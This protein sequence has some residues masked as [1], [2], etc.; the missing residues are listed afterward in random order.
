MTKMINAKS[1]EKRCIPKSS[2]RKTLKELSGGRSISSKGLEILQDVAEKHI[3][4]LF[5]VGKTIM[6]MSNRKTVDAK[7]VALAHILS[8]KDYTYKMVH[9]DMVEESVSV[10]SE[11]DSDSVVS[12]EGD[13][14]DSEEE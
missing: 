8:E 2:F 7:D 10:V 11:E 4:E 13:N 1:I 9:Q 12:E 3:I 5:A 14:M 6:E